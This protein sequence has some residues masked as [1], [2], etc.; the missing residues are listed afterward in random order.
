MEDTFKRDLKRGQKIEDVVL[1]RIKNK[2]PKAYI[3]EGYKKEW[4]IFIPELNLGVEVK[5]DEKSKLTGN[6][7]I[8]INFNGKA[9]GIS[10]TKAGYWVIYD[11]KEYNW[12]TT[13][14]IHKC[15]ME[16]KGLKRSK[17]INVEGKDLIGFLVPKE[18]LYKYK[19]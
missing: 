4:D 16:N 12:F 9:S 18:I 10:T 19:A 14:N 15:L 1:A 2:Y 13:D 7:F 3:E 17:T 8:E 5:F 11:G 6:I